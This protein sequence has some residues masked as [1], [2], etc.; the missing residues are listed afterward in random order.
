MS[1]PTSRPLFRSAPSAD[2]RRGLRIAQAI[3]AI[4]DYGVP[5]NAAVGGV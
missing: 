1:Q 5:E 3:D 2:G 4:L